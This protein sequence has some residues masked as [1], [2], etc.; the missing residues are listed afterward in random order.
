MDALKNLDKQY[1]VGTGMGLISLTVTIGNGCD[2]TIEVSIGGR[3]QGINSRD[4]VTVP[5][6]TANQLKDQV[7]KVASTSTQMNSAANAIIT[8]QFK[9]GS[10]DVPFT[11]PPDGETQPFDASRI[12]QFLDKF[13]MVAA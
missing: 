9:G 8:Y 11:N 5:L 6:G 1:V 13:T 2:G 10:D 4:T 3:S 7:I 12:V